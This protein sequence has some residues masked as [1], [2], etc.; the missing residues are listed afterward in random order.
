[1]STND[2]N[3]LAITNLFPN[4]CE[5]QKGVFNKQQFIAL[6]A[7]AH[8]R[9]I[10]P[11]PW[12]P[13]LPKLRRWKQWYVFAEVPRGEMID[14]IEV[15]HPRYVNLPKIGRR[16][17]ATAFAAAIRPTLRRYLQAARPHCVLAT[18]AYPDIVAAVRLRRELH[19]PIVAKVHGTDINVEAA[20]GWRRRVVAD[21]L[22]QCEAVVCVSAG[23]QQRVLALG[24]KPDRVHLVGNG[25]DGH[26]FTP[27]DQA[28][29]RRVLGLALDGRLIVFIGNLVPV[30]GP[31]VLMLAFARLQ[32]LVN[33][34]P[35]RLVVVGDGWM[36]SELEKQAAGLMAAGLVRFVGS[37]PH[38]EIATWLGAAD[39][40]C[41]PSRQ[42][43]CPNVVLEALASGRPVVA[44]RTGGLQE[45]IRPPMNG[46]LVPAED[47]NV[48]AQALHHALQTEWNPHQ[49]R[50]SASMSWE[51]NAARLLDVLRGATGRA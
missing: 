6:T 44:S 10:A 31:D 37:R 4:A 39:V 20:T 49:I 9:V 41:L 33:V 35:V 36:R 18:W 30:K 19:A 1:M 38:E 50:Q 46:L 40:L 3:V 26:R 14:G 22:Q 13:R 42:E 48:L 25:V 28:Q 21:A 47:R 17:Y 29:C 2:L 51:Q 5:P 8:V 16:W 43:G 15:S 12:F 34:A 27:Q 23:L 32:M 45:L 7:H 24:V 11:V